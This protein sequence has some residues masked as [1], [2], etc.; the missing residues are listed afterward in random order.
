MSKTITIHGID[1]QV[2]EADAARLHAATAPKPGKVWGEVTPWEQ[3]LG[4]NGYLVAIRNAS[5]NSELINLWLKNG[6]P[7]R[8]LTPTEAL[9]LARALVVAA[10]EKCGVVA[11]AGRTNRIVQ[12]LR[13]DAD[14]VLG[15]IDDLIQSVGEGE[16]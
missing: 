15:S 1:V 5:R 10:A 3:G 6:A 13:P 7:A 11:P 14:C 4:I 12:G 16:L 9:Q 8:Y 2:S